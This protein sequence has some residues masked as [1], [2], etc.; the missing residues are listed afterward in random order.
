[1]IGVDFGTTNSVVTCLDPDG[2]AHTVRHRFGTADLDI[3]RSVLCFSTT[4]GPSRRLEHAA[5]PDAI[6]H[7]IDDPHDTRLMMS[8]KTYLAQASFT[9]TLVFGR[10]FTLEALIALFLRAILP[11]IVPGT[12]LTAGR[13]VRFVGDRPDDALGERRLRGAYAL[14]GWPDIDTALEP[15]A[16]GYRFARALAVP[17]TV[18]IGDFGGGTSDFSIMRFEPRGTR[19]VTALEQY[20]FKLRQHSDKIARQN[21]G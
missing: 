1:M 6:E 3:V 16:A 9:E 19:P 11:G 4:D 14:A 21:K 13:P 12:V 2:T 10:P 8:L 18:L 5:G 17:A 20:R 15:E 7:T